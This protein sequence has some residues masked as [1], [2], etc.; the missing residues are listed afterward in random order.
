MDAGIDALW[1]DLNEPAANAMDEAL[2]DFDGQPRSD[3]QARDLYALRETSLTSQAQRERAPNTRPWVLSRS[4][5]PGIQRYAAN[6]SGDTLTSWD[7]LRVD[8]QTALSV[9]LSGQN[10]FGHDVGGFLGTPDAELFTRWLQ[11]ASLSTYFRTHSLQNVPPREPW[12]FG[13]PWTGI[14]RAVIEQRYRWLPTLY[15]LHEAASRTG[16]PVLAPTFF[17]FPEDS[18][19]FAQDSVFMVGPSLL[20]APV[21]TQAAT[22]RSLYLPAGN[23][24]YDVATDVRYAGG[25]SVTVPAPI[26]RIPVLARAGSVVVAAPV[27]Q[28]VGE[29]A[30]MQLTADIY[31]GPAG[32]FTLYED[33]GASFG[34]QSG[35]FLRTRIDHALVG[36]RRI[37]TLLRIAGHLQPVARD[38]MVQV[39]GTSAAPSRV[40]SGSATLPHVAS[41]A[42]LAS[43][44]TGWFHRADGLLLVKVP[45][46]SA[47]SLW[48]DP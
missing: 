39:H 24:W 4:G 5:Y 36:T 23:D 18:A 42:A 48:I 26:E 16:A 44:A 32:S 46:A 17:H 27:V 20:V 33:D 3:Q 30:A 35:A 12:R 34:Y 10:Q 6:W 31:G 45:D 15:T 11:F 2:Y 7:S 22:T 19:T 29:S 13:D 41:E 21:I 28:F 43:V 25:Q 47:T 1:N 9:G 38:W 14:N 8:V 40:R 37:V